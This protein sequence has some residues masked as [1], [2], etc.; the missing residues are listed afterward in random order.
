VGPVGFFVG[1]VGFF[2]GLGG[3]W[4]LGMV[5]ILWVLWVFLWVL[6][7]FLWVSGVF[8]VWG[9]STFCGSCGFFCGSCGLFLWVS[10]VFGVWG[11][12]T[13]CGSCGFF[14]GSCG[15]FCG[16]R[17]SLGSVDRRR[18]V[19]LGGLWGG[20]M[21]GKFPQTAFLTSPL[22]ASIASFLHYLGCISVVVGGVVG[23]RTVRSPALI[24]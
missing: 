24:S 6:W 12:S 15:L 9:W 1:I 19:C 22:T 11:W 13:F 4:G 5:D 8:G 10:G 3:L 23:Y 7:A 18:L 16:S 14:C 20:G 21:H 17:G 2:V